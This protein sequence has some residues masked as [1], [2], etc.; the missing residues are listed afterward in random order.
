MFEDAPPHTS[1]R[2]KSSRHFG[3]TWPQALEEAPRFTNIA[4][5]R[6]LVLIKTVS[7]DPRCDGLKPIKT[8]ENACLSGVRDPQLVEFSIVV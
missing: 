4:F 6:I 3:R 2:S 7:R 8:T 5:G 1:W